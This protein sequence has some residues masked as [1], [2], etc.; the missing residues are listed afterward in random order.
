MHYEYM[1]LVTG[2]QIILVEMILALSQFSEE[3]H[4]SSQVGEGRDEYHFEECV[5]QIKLMHL[6][7]LYS[8][9]NI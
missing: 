2:L 1:R 8:F 6:Y 7:H 3:F 5:I 9:S 4:F